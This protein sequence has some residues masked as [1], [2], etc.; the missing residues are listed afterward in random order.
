MPF[1]ESGFR[2]EYATER[3]HLDFAELTVRRFK[4]GGS[5]IHGI[6]YVNNQRAFVTLEVVEFEEVAPSGCGLVHGETGEI[7]EPDVIVED[8]DKDWNLEGTIPAK[9]VKASELRGKMCVLQKKRRFASVEV[10]AHMLAVDTLAEQNLDLK[11]QVAKQKQ[12][13]V[14]VD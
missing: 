7:V 4:D 1:C 3:V 8:D 5:N 10:S 11:R 12:V 9:E 6:S 14:E 13:F 2:N